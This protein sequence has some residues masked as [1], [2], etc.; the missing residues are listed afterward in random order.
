MAAAGAETEGV[1]TSM[2]CNDKAAVEEGTETCLPE[3]PSSHLLDRVCRV[4]IEDGRV[5][6]GILKVCI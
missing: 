2:S 4:T 6:V 3:K 5:L 1:S